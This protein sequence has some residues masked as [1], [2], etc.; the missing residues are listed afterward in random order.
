MKI[1]LDKY[2][3]N[4]VLASKLTEFTLDFIGR[5]NINTIIEP[6]AGNGSFSNYLFD[7]YEKYKILAYDI[8]P[9]E[10]RIIKQ[11]FLDLDL[12]YNDK[13]LIIGNPPFGERDNLTKFFFK[14]SITISKYIAFILSVNNLNNT[15]QLY[16]Y[17]LVHS[18][19]LGILKYS[20]RNIH[21]CFNIYERPKNDK[22]NKSYNKYKLDSIKLIHKSDRLPKEDAGIW[23]QKQNDYDIAIGMWGNTGKVFDIIDTQS[24]TFYKI[25]I[26][27]KEEIKNKVLNVIKTYDWVNMKKH[28]SV[29]F[30][31][32]NDIWKVLRE[33]IPELNEDYK[34]KQLFNF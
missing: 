31:C 1:E 5:D 29:S 19:D 11:N 16:H 7:K 17:D 15:K 8:Q 32:K 33:E 22:L 12:K 20:N 13:C 26:N 28:I 9:E 3:T 27:L 14:K 4:K 6:S 21:C 23:F 34:A 18:E 30:I 24:G 25:K 10:N 2:Y